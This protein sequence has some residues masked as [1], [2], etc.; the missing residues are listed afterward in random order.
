MFWPLRASAA[1]PYHFDK[2]TTAVVFPGTSNTIP[3]SFLPSGVKPLLFQPLL[4]PWDIPAGNPFAITSNSSGSVST[5]NRPSDVGSFI[6]VLLIIFTLAW[7]SGWRYLL[8]ILTI[9][10]NCSVSRIA[11]LCMAWY[12][13]QSMFLFTSHLKIV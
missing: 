5:T 10:F 11:C 4:M 1:C 9:E 7:T 2:S 6:S 3:K 12:L 8:G 13:S